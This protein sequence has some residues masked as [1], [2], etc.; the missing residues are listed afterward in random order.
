MET[1]LNERILLAIF[2]FVLILNNINIIFFFYKKFCKY[3]QH[4]AEVTDPKVF[5]ELAAYWEGEFFKDIKALNV[6]I[7]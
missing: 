6:N 5:R 7:F 3:K 1:F 2:N 4:G